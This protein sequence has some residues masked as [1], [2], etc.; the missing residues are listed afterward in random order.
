MKKEKITTPEDV[1]DL[2]RLAKNYDENKLWGKLN[3]MPR[4]TLNLILEKVMIVR[5]LLFDGS[6]PLWVKGTLV[7]VSSY[8]VMPMDLVPD[9][10]PGGFLDDA[11][12]LGLVLANLDYLVTD[13]IRQRVRVRMGKPL[14]KT[15]AE[16]KDES[17]EE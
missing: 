2:S 17:L 8:V 15:A 6:T 4:S 1:T 14:P 5:E 16:A 9:F 12:M 3:N 10:L 13:D 11:A 7:G